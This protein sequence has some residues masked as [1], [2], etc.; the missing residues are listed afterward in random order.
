VNYKEYLRLRPQDA[1][2]QASLAEALK[3][4]GQ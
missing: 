1:S 4:K 3:A 2:A